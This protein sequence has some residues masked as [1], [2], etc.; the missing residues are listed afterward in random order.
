VILLDTSALIAMP[1]V[2]LPDEPI[3]LSILAYAELAFGIEAARSAAERGARR[4][5]L[6]RLDAMGLEWL[7]FDKEAAHGYAAV[8]ALAREVRPALA[9]TKD[10]MLAGHA[11]AL[12]ASIATLNA[13]DFAPVAQLVPVVE[14]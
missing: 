10:M 13:R 12:G 3:C 14:L 2:V 11:Y 1:G 4:E 5:R 8:A 7:P 9:R 6:V